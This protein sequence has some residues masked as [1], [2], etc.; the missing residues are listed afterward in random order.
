VKLDENQDGKT[1]TVAGGPIFANCADDALRY[2]T[3]PPEKGPL[4]VRR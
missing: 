3:V 1:G 2:L 4:A